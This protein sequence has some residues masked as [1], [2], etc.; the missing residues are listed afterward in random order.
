MLVFYQKKRMKQFYYILL[1]TVAFHFAVQAQSSTKS[2]IKKTGKEIGH[3]GKKFGKQ[4]GKAGK[5]AGHSLKKPAKQ[6]G[7][8]S[9]KAAKEVGQEAKKLVK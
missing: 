4:V 1:M 8:E 2:E 5:E 7:R 3:T 6:V 9:K